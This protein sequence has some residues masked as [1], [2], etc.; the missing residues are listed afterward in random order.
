MYQNL[1]NKQKENKIKKVLHLVSKAY[2]HD[3]FVNE[4][5]KMVNKL[6][7]KLQPNQWLR[8]SDNNFKNYTTLNIKQK[9]YIDLKPNGIWSSKGE[10]FFDKDKYLIFLEIDYSKILVLT[11][12]EDLLEFEKHY[13]KQIIYKPRKQQNTEKTI[14]NNSIKKKHK[15]HTTQKKQL[16]CSMSINWHKVAKDY[17]GIAIVPNPDWYFPIGISKNNIDFD[18]RN[19]LWLRAYD[20]SSLVIWRNTDNTIIKYYEIGKISNLIKLTEDTQNTLEDIILQK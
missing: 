3:S 10:W 15:K 8:V 9:R 13:C 11:T 6:A 7:M 17:N 4:D 20:V 12:K 19:H 2:D 14:H 16:Y 18:I 1:T 5:E